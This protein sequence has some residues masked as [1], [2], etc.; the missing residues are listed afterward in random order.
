MGFLEFLPMILSMTSQLMGAGKGGPMPGM[1]MPGGEATGS[2]L[3]HMVQAAKPAAAPD[4]YTMPSGL[5]HGAGSPNPSNG[6]PGG[7]YSNIAQ[8]FGMI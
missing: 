4:T 8:M 3:S 5:T 6:Q 7:Q 2:N 1:S